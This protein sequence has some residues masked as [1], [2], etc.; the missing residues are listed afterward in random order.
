MHCRCCTLCSL[1]WCLAPL[2]IR[3]GTL[4]ECGVQGQQQDAGSN[5]QHAC[6]CMQHHTTRKRCNSPQGNAAK[7]AR[8]QPFWVNL[9]QRAAA[10]ATAYCLAYASWQCRRLQLPCGGPGSHAALCTSS[11]R[12]NECLGRHRLQQ[13]QN[14]QVPESLQPRAISCQA[15]GAASPSTVVSSSTSSWHA[16]ASSAAAMLLSGTQ[17]VDV[18]PYGSRHEHDTAGMLASAVPVVLI[19]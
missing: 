4:C 11:E 17:P 16:T 1:A 3:I 14:A 8:T 2:A 6:C 15:P 18:L 12:E 9:S 13:P 10:V 5:M 19:K 7:L